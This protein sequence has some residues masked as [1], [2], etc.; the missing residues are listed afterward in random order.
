MLIVGELDDNV[1]PASTYQLVNQLIKQGKDHEFIMVPGMGHASGGDFG[2]KKRR[3]FFV[4]H[5]LGVNPPA[6]NLY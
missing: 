2:E 4:K 5:L 3:D 6:W 1:D